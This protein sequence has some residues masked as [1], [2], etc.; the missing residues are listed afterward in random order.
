MAVK[1]VDCLVIGAGPAGM[2]AAT[3]LARFRRSVVVADDADSLA[4]GIPVSHNIP[5]FADG[6]AGPDLLRRHREQLSIYGIVP[7]P[8]RIQAV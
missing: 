2:T 1:S 8:G 5:G 4:S 7:R 3:Y 6:L